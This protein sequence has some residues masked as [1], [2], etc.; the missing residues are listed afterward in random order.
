M[1]SFDERSQVKRAIQNWLSYYSGRPKERAK[2]EK[3]KA[4]NPETATAEEIAEILESAQWACK[5]Y[6]DECGSLSWEIVAL[7][8][9]VRYSTES[10]AICLT[11]LRK[12]VKLAEE[13]QTRQSKPMR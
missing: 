3:L 7:G 1:K 4:L 9:D 12:A 5:V 10:F 6:C 13:A 8:G 11:C 2:E